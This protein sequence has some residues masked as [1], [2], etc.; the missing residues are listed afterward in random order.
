MITT[1]FPFGPTPDRLERLGRE[2]ALW[3]DAERETDSSQTPPERLTVNYLRH[4]CTD[5][6]LNPSRARH[7]AACEAIGRRFPWLAQECQRQID[8]RAALEAASEEGRKQWSAE[9]E[10]RRAE[11]RAMVAASRELVKGMRVGQRVAFRKGR[12][13]Y[14]GVV[15]KLGR[16]RVT[17]AYRVSTGRER[18]RV[19]LFH[20]A[21]LT[22]VE[23][24]GEPS[25]SRQVIRWPRPLR[26]SGPSPPARIPDGLG[27]APVFADQR[28][29]VS[30]ATGQ[31]ARRT[32]GPPRPRRPRLRG[33]CTSP[34]RSRSRRGP[35]GR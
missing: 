20:A 27:C 8:R 26:P 31:R 2:H 24:D 1:F 32:R 17:V 14:T 16:S 19:R 29:M 10:R 13:R 5:Y 22:P 35:A 7:R 15:T 9:M 33:P 11:H 12:N 30:P 25:P 28:R 18:D 6:D 34:S 3:L 23:E 21:R 4:E